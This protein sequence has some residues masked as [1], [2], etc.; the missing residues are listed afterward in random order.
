MAFQVAE[1][2]IVL[3]VHDEP[4]EIQVRLIFV[5][6]AV[7]VPLAFANVQLSPVGCVLIDTA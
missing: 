1:E 3:L 4:S 5:M 6:F 2:G 7:A